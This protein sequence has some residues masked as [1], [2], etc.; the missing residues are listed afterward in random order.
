MTII[1]Q[2]YVILFETSSIISKVKRDIQ[3]NNSMSIAHQS[4]ES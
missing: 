4:Y 2:D 1:G 3:D